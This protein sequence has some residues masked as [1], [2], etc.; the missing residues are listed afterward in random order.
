M[1]ED[2]V[3]ERH[4]GGAEPVVRLVNV[5]KRIGKRTIIDNLTFDVPPGEVFG[6]LGPNGS[7]KTTTI[8][9]MV[10]LMRMTSGEIYIKG[11]SIRT[12]FE[13]AVRQVGAIVENP[14]MYKFL[15]GY[16]NLV[17]YARMIPGI[18][19]RR[20]DEVV[21]LVGLSDRIHDKVKTYSLGMRQ[22]LGV[23]HGLLQRPA[24]LGLDEPT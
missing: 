10:G 15:T 3:L 19:K 1:E 11:R 5:T 21:E 9:M 14:E 8:R 6:F 23:G 24:R 12:E 7:G 16:Q 20:I 22:R 13:A 2:S 4:G 17:H 18:G